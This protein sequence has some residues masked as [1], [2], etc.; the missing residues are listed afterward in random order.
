[1]LLRNKKTT[2]RVDEILMQ[3][4]LPVPLNFLRNFHFGSDIK[5]LKL[6]RGLLVISFKK[7]QEK[8]Q[9]L[10]ILSWI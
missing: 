4:R 9:K 5:E 8:S 6:P 10:I 1:M 3:N 7:N 2:F